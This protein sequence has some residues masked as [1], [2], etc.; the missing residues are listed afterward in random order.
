MKTKTASNKAFSDPPFNFHSSL[1]AYCD[2]HE[3]DTVMDG[4]QPG[5]PRVDTPG[6]WNDNRD[7]IKKYYLGQGSERKHTL[8]ELRA[9]LIEK[10]AFPAVP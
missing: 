4:V 9:T 1:L 2:N 10:H 3:A 7:L 8:D 5:P 6:L